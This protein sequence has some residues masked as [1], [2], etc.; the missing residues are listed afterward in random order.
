VSV[1]RFADSFPAALAGIPSGGLVQDLGG[2]Q[3]DHA[4]NDLEE[5]KEVVD[6]LQ[7]PGIVRLRVLFKALLIRRF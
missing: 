5:V 4:E 2:R 6:K 1:R 3:D 7:P